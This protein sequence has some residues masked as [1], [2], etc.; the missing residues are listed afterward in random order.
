MKFAADDAQNLNVMVSYLFIIAHLLPSLSECTLPPSGDVN[1]NQLI[2]LC[3][4]P[5]MFFCFCFF[6]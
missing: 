4:R 3:E 5:T 1:K 6:P 2:S